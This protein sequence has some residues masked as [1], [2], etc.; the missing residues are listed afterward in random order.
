MQYLAGALVRWFS[1]KR[2]KPQPV[3]DV[4]D[5]AALQA[6]IENFMQSMPVTRVKPGSYAGLRDPATF[7]GDWKGAFVYAELEGEDGCAGAW[8]LNNQDWT[9]RNKPLTEVENIVEGYVGK[10]WQPMTLEDIKE[11]AGVQ[12]AD[13]MPRAVQ[14]VL[15]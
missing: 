13:L 5:P 12:D 2:P 1:F 8:F 9:F 10:G 6:L 15:H 14:S 3:V 11:T 4:N 7:L